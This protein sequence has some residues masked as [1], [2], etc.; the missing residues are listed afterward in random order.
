MGNR[1]LIL[2]MLMLLMP[3]SASAKTFKI[4]TISPDGLA[5]MKSLRAG[6][7]EI[8]A[9]TEGRV[10]FKIYPGGVQGDD[11]T[12]LRKMRIGQLHGGA[13]S[14]S[15]L[16]RF[17]PDL[18]VYSLPLVFESFDEVDYV[19]KRMDQRIIDGLAENGIVSFSLTETGF[20]YLLSDTQVATLQELRRKETWVPSGDPIAAE[21]IKSFGISPIPL[22]IT[23]VLAGLQTGLVDAVTVPPLVSLALQW[24]NHVNYMIDVPLVYTYSMMMLDKKAFASVSPDDQRIVTEVMNRVFSQV[25]ADNRQ[26]NLDA[27][28]ALLSYGVELTQP[29]QE[30][31]ALWK[32]RARQ[33]IED[34][35]S[36]G[37][38]SSES[39]RLLNGY[40]AEVRSAVDPHLESGTG[41]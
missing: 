24:H 32:D 27:R 5:W 9:R 37:G 14:S 28:D 22:F 11:L 39:L 26:D 19:R 36:S 12:V 33:S 38:I 40:L 20:A 29:S 8:E 1:I 30:Q 15:S 21:L 4:A 41:H 3:V 16:T 25:D 13:V 23:D 10:T 31:L 35:V 34:L 6:A 7:E 17:Y 18:Q 2:A